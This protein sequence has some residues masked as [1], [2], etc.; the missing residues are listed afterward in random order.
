MFTVFIIMFVIRVSLLLNEI[1]KCDLC[2]FFLS[3]SLKNIFFFIH[4]A[5]FKHAANLLKYFDKLLKKKKGTLNR[6]TDCINRSK[7]LSVG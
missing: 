7:F 5:Y 1:I 3:L 6:L 2:F 4:V